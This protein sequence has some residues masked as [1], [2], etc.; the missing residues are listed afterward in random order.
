LGLGYGTTTK[1]GILD[2]RVSLK[3]GQRID[4]KDGLVFLPS[5]TH[6][7]NEILIRSILINK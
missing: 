4:P 5:P 6:S 2:F 7:N 1:N 3:P